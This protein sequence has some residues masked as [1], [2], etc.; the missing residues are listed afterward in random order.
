MGNV[1]SVEAKI[2]TRPLFKRDKFVYKPPLMKRAALTFHPS[3]GLIH[4]GG[5]PAL[6]LINTA[7]IR[8]SY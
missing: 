4:L 2:S 5:A 3:K 8:Q 6:P 1:L 7:A